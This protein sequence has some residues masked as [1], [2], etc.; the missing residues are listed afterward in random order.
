MFRGLW[1]KMVLQ[2][3]NYNIPPE[4]EDNLLAWI[5]SLLFSNTDSMASGDI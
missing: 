4:I 5:S 3:N 1:K 2:G